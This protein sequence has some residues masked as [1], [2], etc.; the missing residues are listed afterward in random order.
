MWKKGNKGNKENK[1][2]YQWGVTNEP[3]GLHMRRITCLATVALLIAFVPVPS[4][5]ALVDIARCDGRATLPSLGGSCFDDFTVSPGGGVFLIPHA[6]PAFTGSLRVQVTNPTAGYAIST[7]YILGR[8]VFSTVNGA[9]YP[10]DTLLA[11][12]SA[13]SWRLT[14]VAGD[15]MFGTGP[16]L[17]FALGRF[18]GVAAAEEPV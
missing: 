3:G 13:G 1:E 17:G 8:R 11:E 14:V 18:D 16:L 5:A 10:G 7:F 2:N 6:G 12:L 9:P 4:S 15:S